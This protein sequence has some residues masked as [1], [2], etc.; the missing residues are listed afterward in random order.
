MFGRHPRT[1]LPSIIPTRFNQI[2]K[3]PSIKEKYDKKSKDLPPISPDT[4]VRIYSRSKY[5]NWKQK[6]EVISKRHKPRSYDVINE[7]GNIIRR[8]R[9]QL[10]PTNETF[11]EVETN[12]YDEISLP[13]RDESDQEV[14]AVELEPAVV[15]AIET[16]SG[17]ETKYGRISKP[18]D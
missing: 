12:N 18:P 3:D 17:Y 9:W 5:G 15:P 16:Y 4:T 7:K 10:L 2:E 11:N 6:G 13:I 14:P 1:T 8:N